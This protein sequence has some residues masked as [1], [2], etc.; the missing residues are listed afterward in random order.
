M[1]A[2][3]ERIPPS[4]SDVIFPKS[5]RSWGT[6][7]RQEARDNPHLIQH[8]NHDLSNALTTMSIFGPAHAYQSTP[9]DEFFI[10]IMSNDS[11]NRKRI[12]R[13]PESELI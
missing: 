5:L 2:K 3:V 13:R 8:R 1:E 6:T 7:P 11:D 9:I 10:Q 12:R 4:D